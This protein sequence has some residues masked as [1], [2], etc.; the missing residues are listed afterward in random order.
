[1]LRELTL[2]GSDVQGESRPSRE[3][4]FRGRLREE[5]RAVT[6][7]L[8]HRVVAA[9]CLAVLSTACLGPTPFGAESDER[10]LNRKN[11]ARLERQRARAESLRLAII[12]DTHAE[13]DALART[14]RAL[15]ADDLDMVLHLGDQTNLGLLREF[16]WTR[17]VMR[18]TEAPLLFT[19]GNH[20]AIS[21]GE[22]IYRRM[23]GPLDYGFDYAGFH[24][25]VFNSNTLEFPGSAPNVDWLRSEAL[26][27]R[28]RSVILVTH[29]GPDTSDTTAVARDLYTVLLQ[30]GCVALWL[31]GHVAGIT[32]RVVAGVPVVQA[33]TYQDQRQH[34]RVEFD[35]SEFRFERCAFAE[36]SP[37][38]LQPDEP[39]TVAP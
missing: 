17:D 11:L 8:G 1:M 5:R 38:F 34:V 2:V 37:L 12:T 24:F 29:H 22:A 28:P 16:E 3:A 20:D 39:A 33:G 4:R 13:Y 27:R 19:I 23:Y 30:S 10:D 35:G 9:A 6:A 21:S 31:H 14:V 25:V 36:C 15:N 26:G 7:T 32:R 18:E